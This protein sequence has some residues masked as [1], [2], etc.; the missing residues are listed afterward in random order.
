M[1]GIAGGAWDGSTKILDQATAQQMTDVLC[2]RGPDGDGMYTSTVRLRADRPM[3]AGVALGHRRLSVIDLVG[4]KQPLANEDESVWVVFNGEIYNFAPLRR[5]LEAA[6]HRFRTRSDTE[7]LVHLY[8]D[9]GPG[10]LKFI[11]GMYGIAI[12]DA[13]QNLLL[14]ARDRLGKKPVLYYQEPGRLL[15]ASEMKSLLEVPDVPREVDP[16]SLDAFLLYQSVPYP[17]TIFRGITKLPPGHYAIYRDDRL[18]VRPYWQPDFNLE[19][20]RSMRDY[21]DELRA[22]MLEAVEMRLQSEVPLGVF[23]SGGLDSTILTGLASHLMKEPVRTFSIGSP[24]PEYDE[25]HYARIAAE[26]FKTIHQEYRIRPN[27]LEILPQLVWHYDEPFADSSAIPIWYV[28]QIARQNVTVALSG[29]GADE[30]FAGYPRHAG[31]QWAANFDRLP[32]WMRSTFLKSLALLVPKG[33]SRQKSLC[34]R[35]RRLGDYFRASPRDR[36]L[37]WISVFDAVR[38]R[39]LYTDGFAASLDGSA[40][41]EFLFAAMR[42]SSRRDPL[43]NASITD[44]VT[45]LPCTLMFKADI[46]SMA[47]GLELRQPFLDYRVVELVTRMPAKLK[48]YRSRGK[49]ILRE[50]FADLLPDEIRYRGKMGFCVP[51]DYWFRHELRDYTRQVLLDRRTIERGYF[52]PQAVTRL[53]DEHQTGMADHSV[54]LWSLLFLEL[55]HRQWADGRLPRPQAISHVE[56]LPSTTVFAESATRPAM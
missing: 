34:R 3:A 12:W 15:F 26:K 9:H 25:T 32:Q 51:L 43:S 14:L 36:Y 46:A 22:L 53:L 33:G 39:A 54:R 38:R 40:P 18:E 2:H 30:L 48:A 49:R 13:K 23:L 4:G 44:L 29:E 16:E 56:V 20:N 8:E 37:E 52:S 55:W 41:E 5:Q 24:V 7:V 50:C 6:G 31:M 1:C 11:N 27:A 35:I 45:Y 47:H 10:F 21:G 19:E 42:R 17:R 28:S